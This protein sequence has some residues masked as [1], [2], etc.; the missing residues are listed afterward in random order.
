[1]VCSDRV[2]ERRTLVPESFSIAS[3]TS[4]RSAWFSMVFGLLRLSYFT[5][6]SAAIHVTR[7]FWA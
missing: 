1:M 7:Q 6:P 3:R 5:V 4:C 2:D